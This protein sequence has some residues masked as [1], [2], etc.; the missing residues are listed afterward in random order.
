LELQI[1]YFDRR[2]TQLKERLKNGCGKAYY[3]D[4]LKDLIGDLF[5][6]Q[7]ELGNIRKDVE[8]SNA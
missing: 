7:A 3:V 8:I 5:A 6:K 2:I 1:A 4:M